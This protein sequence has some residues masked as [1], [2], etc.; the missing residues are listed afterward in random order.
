M[1]EGCKITV[2]M[3][4]H[5]M[6]PVPTEE[7]TEYT[8]KVYEVKKVNGKLGFDGN[9]KRSPYT[10]RGEVFT[11]FQAYAHAVI[12]KDTETGKLYRYSEIEKGLEEVPKEEAEKIKWL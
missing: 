11:P 9:E 2:H 5:W 7:K 3:T 1:K 6:Y 12:F 4:N 10:S 8:G